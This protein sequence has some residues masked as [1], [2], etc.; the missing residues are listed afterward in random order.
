V[1]VPVVAT[2]PSGSALA[3]ASVNQCVINADNADQTIIP[4]WI[5][6]AASPY[7]RVKARLMR[8]DLGGNQDPE[9]IVYVIGV[10]FE[11]PDFF[12]SDPRGPG[13]D[14][15]P[16]ATGTDQAATGAW[17]TFDPSSGTPVPFPDNTF[18]KQIDVLAIFIKDAPDG[19][20]GFFVRGVW[21]AVRKETGDGYAVV[22]SCYCSVDPGTEFCRPIA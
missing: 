10:P 4:S 12:R 19:A 18:V 16:P 17:P 21:P 22:Q 6:P 9:D 1:S 2:L 11:I 20:T 5:E 13:Q 8:Y 7:L 14:T 3:N 15:L